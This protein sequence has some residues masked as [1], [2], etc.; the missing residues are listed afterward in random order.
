MWSRPVRLPPPAWSDRWRT[1]RPGGPPWPAAGRGAGEGPGLARGNAPFGMLPL[2]SAT[3]SLGGGAHGSWVTE[4]QMQARQ[5]G[6]H[7]HSSAAA[8]QGDQAQVPVP[9]GGPTAARAAYG[10]LGK[11]ARPGWARGGRNLQKT[12]QARR[13]RRQRQD[14]A[15]PARQPARPSA[16]GRLSGWA[17]SP[18]PACPET[19]PR[20]AAPPR[21]PTNRVGAPPA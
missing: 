16:C 19:P 12:A 9:A 1:P 17:G 15:G 5:K 7:D 21:D 14:R 10:R 3:Y 4:L 6:R 18:G 20:R 11:A 8:S 2:G 13:L